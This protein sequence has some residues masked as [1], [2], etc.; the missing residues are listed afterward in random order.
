MYGSQQR[1]AVS[2]QRAAPLGLLLVDTQ[3]FRERFQG[4]LRSCL[5]VTCI[6]AHILSVLLLLPKQFVGYRRPNSEI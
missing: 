5:E 4:S 3:G 6:S 2:I 1:D